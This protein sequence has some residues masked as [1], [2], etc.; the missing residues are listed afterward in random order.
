MKLENG[1]Q[2]LYWGNIVLI[3]IKWVKLLWFQGHGGKLTQGPKISKEIYNNDN[4]LQFWG[5]EIGS[6][7]WT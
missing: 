7:I 4:E 2:N 6:R 1:R 3:W 5:I